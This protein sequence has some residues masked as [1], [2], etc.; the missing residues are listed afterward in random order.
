MYINE[1]SESERA[2]FVDYISKF[3]PDERLVMLVE[4]LQETRAQTRKDMRA[5]AKNMGANTVAALIEHEE[6]RSA[7]AAVIVKSDEPTQ[8]APKGK[9]YVEPP[10]EA[11]TRITESSRDKILSLTL[12]GNT[13]ANIHKALGGRP[14]N[15]H[16]L[17]KLLYTRQLIKFDGDKYYNWNYDEKSI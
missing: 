14:D 12:N 16:R 7:H 13:F 3:L 1:L 6:L 8:E 17:L 5:C 10:S 4:E 2:L 9:V 15:T 11:A